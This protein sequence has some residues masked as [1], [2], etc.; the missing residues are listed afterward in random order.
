MS[1][2]EIQNIYDYSKSKI[3]ICNKLGIRLNQN[4]ISLDNS[5]LKYFS[6]IGINS[7]DDI[8]KKNLSKHWLEIQK[9][10]YKLNPKYCENCGKILPFEK[11]FSKCCNQSCGNSLGN[12]KKGHRSEETK[13]KISVSIHKKYIENPEIFHNQYTN[14]VLNKKP[15]YKY[16]FDLINDNIILNDDN[17]NYINKEINI[18]KLYEHT[19][20]L[21]GRVFY[22]RINKFGKIS[23]GNTCSEKCHHDLV[24]N[25][26]KNLRLK[27]IA[28]KTFKGWQSRNITSYPEKFWKTV[29]DN[30]DIKYEL[31][32]PI[33]QDN[34]L[35][36]YFLDFYI[37][38]NN[39]KIDLEIDGKQHKYTDRQESD[40]KRDIYIKSKGIEVYRI[41]WNEINSDKGKLLMKEKIDNFLNYIKA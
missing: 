30:N 27:E 21:C 22:G 14:G 34:N 32:F 25:I 13:Q 31:N 33:K 19:C 2:E 9:K 23:S 1:T 11:R 18:N 40:I 15:N 7:R 38:I 16:I 36:N 28:N 26:G 12:K 29:L 20:K 10:D 8:S 24:S 39:R 5:I 3:E 41:E 35:Y 4:G 17:F 6:Q 37:N